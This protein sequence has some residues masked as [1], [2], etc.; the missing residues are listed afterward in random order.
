MLTWYDIDFVVLL[1]SFFS[2]AWVAAT[3]LSRP[4]VVVVVVVI[5][6]VFLSDFLRTESC[7]TFQET[8][9]RSAGAGGND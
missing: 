8:F 6:E 9:L 4:S 3:C 1:E 7:K 5:F 2:V